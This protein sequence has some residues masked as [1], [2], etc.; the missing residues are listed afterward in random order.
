MGLDLN[1]IHQVLAYANDV[2]LICDDIRTIERNADV[3]LHVCKDIGLAVNTGKTN[4]MEIGSH[5]GMI[6]NEH[7]KIGINSY[8]KVKNL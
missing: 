7:I 8:E 3:L 2:N 6:A 4:Y 1:D 5:R